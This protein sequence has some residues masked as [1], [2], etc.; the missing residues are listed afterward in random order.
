MHFNK[1][2]PSSPIAISEKAN[3]VLLGTCKAIETTIEKGLE[4]GLVD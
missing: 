4:G 1:D 3:I 2:I